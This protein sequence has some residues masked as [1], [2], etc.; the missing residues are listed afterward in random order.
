MISPSGSALPGLRGVLG[1]ALISANWAGY[2]LQGRNGAF[3]SV[4]SSW[5]QPT[6]HCSGVGNHRYAAFWVGLDGAKGLADPFVEQ[7]GSDSDCSGST[8]MY[9]GWYEMFPALPVNFRNPVR[10]GD[11]MSASVTFS[12]TRTYVLVLRDSTRRWVQRI[13]KNKAGLQRSSAE[14]I[15]EAPSS[16]RTGNVLP[17]ANFGTVRWTGSRVN[18]TL[19][20]N[21][22]RRSRITMVEQN[23]LNVVKCSTSLVS[24][25]DVFTNRYVRA[26]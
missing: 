16:A 18:G 14:L 19:L 2:V 13:T 1:P 5:I 23:D 15:A 22:P 21:L 25:A 17:L 6:A 3:R 12:G 11:H 20:M 4:S 7:T 24:S 26:T 8:P 9:Y 10:P